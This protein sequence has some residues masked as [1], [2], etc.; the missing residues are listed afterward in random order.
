MPIKND[1]IDYGSHTYVTWCNC[2]WRE[3]ASTTREAIQRIADHRYNVHDIEFSKAYAAVH[4]R[5]ARARR[6]V[7]T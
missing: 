4:S 2:G 5:S 1:G 7:N 3:L 6:A